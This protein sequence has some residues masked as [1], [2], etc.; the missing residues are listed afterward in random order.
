[1]RFA[2]LPV[3]VQSRS[4]VRAHAGNLGSRVQSS[5]GVNVG[6]FAAEV[7]A[8]TQSSSGNRVFAQV[9]TLHHH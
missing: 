8:R 1:M 3:R 6:F 5:Q 4:V 9:V 2:L 7:T